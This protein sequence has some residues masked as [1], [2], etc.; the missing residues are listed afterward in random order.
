MRS[1]ANESLRRLVARDATRLPTGY[2]PATSTVE[3]PKKK[4]PHVSI[5]VAD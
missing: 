4:L 2:N 3:V 5:F 1:F